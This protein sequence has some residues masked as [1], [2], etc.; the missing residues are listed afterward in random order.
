MDEIDKELQLA[1]QDASPGLYSHQE[2]SLSRDFTP[3]LGPTP[4]WPL[5]S[6]APLPPPQGH[7]VQHHHE[8]ENSPT[9]L[10]QPIQR[11]SREIERVA[12]H[13]STLSSATSVSQ[14]SS[15]RRRNPHQHVPPG[16][17]P[18]VPD[19]RR[20]SVMT[21]DM[22]YSGAGP[23]STVMSRVATQADLERHPTALSRIATHRSQHSQTVGRRL[24]T[25]ESR[26]PLPSFGGGK[27]YPPNLPAQEEYVVEFDGPD[28]P[29]H[30]Q[31][32]PMA[33]K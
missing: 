19:T 32:W 7:Q 15:A 4:S 18:P 25:R 28:D 9:R 17:I 24:T 1:A 16:S 21:V 27:P 23:G 31:N 12:S 14:T 29:R 3:G 33:Q 6:T 2:P 20:S 5:S 26:K 22:L 11:D 30:A 10:A 13:A 8:H